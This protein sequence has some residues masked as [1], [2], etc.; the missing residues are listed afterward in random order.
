MV[1]I[2]PDSLERLKRHKYQS[3]GYTWL[4]TNVMNYFWEG[5]VKV[6][7]LWMAPN[8]LTLIGFISILS[9]YVLMTFYD[10]TYTQQLPAW[11]LIYAFF[12]SFSYQTFDACDGKQARR[13]GTSSPLGM[14]MDHG[15]D[16]LTSTIYVLTIVQALG[17]GHDYNLRLLAYGVWAGFYMATWE[18]YHTHWCRV[19]VGNFGVTENQLFE[20]WLMIMAA[21]K[22]LPFYEQPVVIL[23]VTLELRIVFLYVTVSMS[24]G[25][26][27]LML[28]TSV[29]AAENKPRCVARLLPLVLLLGAAYLM[30]HYTSVYH[31]HT[32]LCYLAYA[33]YFSLCV[34]RLILA[35]V[36]ETD[37]NPIQ[38]E[39]FLF[40][41]FL[42]NS[43]YFRTFHS[44]ILPEITAF[45]LLLGV[46]I[47]SYSVFAYLI[48]TELTSA[49]GISFLRI[50]AKA[51]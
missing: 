16:S 50:K 20:M 32:T 31:T 14:L 7:P 28:Y 8:L 51:S 45:Y 22:G 38:F 36:T 17:L 13:T 35:S 25:C 42:A 23:G 5:C 43:L 49:L 3:L 29:K 46:I 26:Q 33:L 40:Y 41:L 15:C 19:Q 37:Y 24:V 12:M 1:L 47:C 6:I 10:T 18:E 34:G 9:A 21:W 4:D 39:G 11:V 44:D 48:I 30:S 27:L 2:P